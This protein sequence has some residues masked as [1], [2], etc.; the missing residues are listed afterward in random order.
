MWVRIV[1]VVVAVDEFYGRRVY[2]VDDSTGEC[3]ECSVEIPKPAK[4]ER[5]G[6]G[7]GAGAAGRNTT[8]QG[9]APAAPTPDIPT[10]MDVG[11][12][13]DVKGRVK[14]FRDRK[15]IRIVKAQRVAST[16]QEVQFWNRIRDFRR[17][18]L[19]RAWVLDRREVHRAKN[20][21]LADLAGVDAEERR[22]R[23]RERRER[24]SRPR[25][26]EEEA[27]PRRAHGETSRRS[28]AD[29]DLAHRP[30]PTTSNTSKQSV[31]ARQAE[32]QYDALGL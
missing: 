9:T 12:V 17:D 14:L 16:A 4:P 27:R 10:D 11:M 26:G 7:A 28:G 8:M 2:T 21:H 23:R 3:V 15:Q 24:K 29:L 20:Q 25:K 32:G 31:K 18:V 1:G 19:A 22:K 5:L 13:V 6:D 30:S